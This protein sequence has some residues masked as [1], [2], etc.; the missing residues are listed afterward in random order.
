MTALTSDISEGFEHNKY[1]LSVFRDLSKAFNILDN[2]ILI[3]NLYKYGIRESNAIR[4]SLYTDD[5]TIHLRVNI[6]RYT[7]ISNDLFSIEYYLHV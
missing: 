5:T 7:K 6:L 2:N 3:Y 4:G 1:T